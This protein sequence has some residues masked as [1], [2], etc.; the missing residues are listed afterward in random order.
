MKT[1]YVIL[2]ITK[3][4]TDDGTDGMVVEVDCKKK[5]L[6]PLLNALDSAEDQLKKR[7][8]SECEEMLYDLMDGLYENNSH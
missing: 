2:R 7:I 3:V 1:D 8:L 6:V 5:D 4:R